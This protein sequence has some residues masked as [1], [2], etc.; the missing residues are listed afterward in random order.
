MP[1]GKLSTKF[2]AKRM[3]HDTKMAHGTGMKISIDE[4]TVQSQMDDFVNQRIQNSLSRGAPSTTRPPLR[5]G[6]PM[7]MRFGL[8]GVFEDLSKSC[9]WTTL[10]VITPES[11]TTQERSGT[12]GTKLAQGNLNMFYEHKDNAQ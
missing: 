8:Q 10:Q 4:K 12:N 1:T 6:V 11:G 7:A 2:S 5:F 9:L 3:A